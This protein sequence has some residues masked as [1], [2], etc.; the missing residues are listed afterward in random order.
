VL[1]AAHDSEAFLAGELVR[2]QALGYPPHATLIRIVTSADTPEAA[3]PAA[4]ALR[5]RL[6]AA[7]V[8]V[9]GPAPLFMLRR[10]ARAQLQIRATDRRAAITAV[11]ETVDGIVG[12]KTARG[13]A[14]SVD[15][16]PQ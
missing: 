2:R 13:V 4:V 1:A 10:R 15:V 16:D 12:T 9:L 14:I 6:D 5:D 11:R 3:W 7:G 8:R